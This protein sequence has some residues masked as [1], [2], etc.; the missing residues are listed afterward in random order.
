VINGSSQDVVVVAGLN[1]DELGLL[2]F[3]RAEVAR[4]RFG[5]PAAWTA[6]PLLAAAPCSD[7]NEVTDK[8]SI[9]QRAVLAHRRAEAERL[10]AE[11]QDDAVI[12]PR[13]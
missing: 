2:I 13:R 9:K 3:P 1:R 4:Q 7:R 8:R 10:Y 11:V 6:A 5:L 12:A